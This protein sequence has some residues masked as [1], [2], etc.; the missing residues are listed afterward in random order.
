MAPVK[1]DQGS[2]LL[3]CHTKPLHHGPGFIYFNIY[4]VRDDCLFCWVKRVLNSILWSI[5]VLKSKLAE[6]CSP[7]SLN[8][9][10]HNV[11]NV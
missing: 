2:L 6:T 5:K 8:L 4:I 1:R 11:M 10:C 3:H 9:R 7:R